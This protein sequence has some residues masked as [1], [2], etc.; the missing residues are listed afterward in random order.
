M[1]VA[2][3]AMLV[4]SGRAH[5]GPE[6]TD[7]RV[8]VNGDKTR[9]VIEVRSSISYNIS[10]LPDP[11]R[12]VIDMTEVEWGTSTSGEGD[13]KGLIQ[14]Y[15]YGLFKPGT[16]RIVLDLASPAR[17]VNDFVI[18]PRGKSGHRLVI[19]LRASDRQVFM[20]SV[21]SPAPPSKQAAMS[22]IPDDKQYART[23]KRLVVID[24]GHGGVDPGSPGVAGLPEKE[25]TLR[26]AR[27]VRDTLNATGRYKAILTRDK[28]IFIPLRQRF[29]VARAA[30]ADLFISLHAD[31]FKSSSVRGA[32]VYTLSETSSDKEAAALAAKENKADIIAGINLGGET[33]DVSSILIDLAQRETMNYS[34][35]F[36]N[37]LVDE[38][39]PH[40]LLRKNTHRFAGFVVLKAPD[41][42]SV[43]LEMGYLSNMQ[44]AKLLASSSHQR[45]LSLAIIRAVDQYFVRVAIR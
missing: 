25:V 34:A 30:N 12:I 21:K 10:L 4:L 31:S 14:R 16:S 43:L 8:G 36:A 5:A 23:G 38:M 40:I 29:A 33:P 22:V 9:F 3:L 35:H 41:V 42:P 27:T 1:L 28:D 15:R 26:V 17:V 44:D 2:C 11:Y 13:G 37:F 18:P 6:V 45:K 39:K 7:L 32:T 24:P 20:S 19:D